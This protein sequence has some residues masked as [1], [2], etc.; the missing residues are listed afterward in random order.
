MTTGRIAAAAL[1]AV[2]LALATGAWSDEPP[3]PA[4]IVVNDS[5]G[6]MGSWMRKAYFDPFEKLYGIPVVE[7]SPT[8]FGKLRAM[9]E[10]G[11]VEWTVTEIGGQDAVRAAKMG[12]VEKIDDS[13]VDRSK[14]P[15]EKHSPSYFS[16][17]VY[18]TVLGY[19]K[20]AFKD[21]HPTSWAEFWDVK[22]FPGPRSMRNHP[23]DNLE[24]ALLADGVAPDQLYPIDMDRAFKKLDEIKSAVTVWWTTGA[25]PAQLLLDKEVVLATGWNGRFFDLILKDAPIDIEWGQ[26]ALKSGTFVIPK[27]AKDAYWGQK[28]LAF[29]TDAKAEAIYA[30]ALAYPGLNP[31]SLQ[32]VDAKVLPYLPTEPTNLKRQFW[33][34]DEW[35]AENGTAAQ[36]RWNQWLL[37]K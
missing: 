2:T 21:G 15:K 17:S 9:V 30:N 29:L 3:K 22:R 18:S 14:F 19:R 1:I 8:D 28:F 26:G 24:F 34:S 6:A 31:D 35:W 32:Y 12:L 25:Q 13:I 37:K 5:G 7:T 10:S 11:N 4:R 23:V 36:E 27:G 20:D 33:I 16:A